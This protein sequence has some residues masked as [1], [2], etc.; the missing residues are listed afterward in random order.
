[1]RVENPGHLLQAGKPDIGDSVVLKPVDVIGR[2]IRLCGQLCL[3][4]PGRL[5]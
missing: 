3:A 4:Q 5:T 1:M 2:Q